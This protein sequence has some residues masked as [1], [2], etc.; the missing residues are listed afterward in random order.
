MELKEL[1]SSYTQ[2]PTPREAVPVLKSAVEVNR[3]ESKIHFTASCFRMI[4]LSSRHFFQHFSTSFNNSPRFIVFSCGQNHPCFTRRLQLPD[5]DL[6]VMQ[7]EVRV[8]VLLPVKMNFLLIFS[9][10]I[11]DLNLSCLILF[12][13]RIC[14]FGRFLL[15]C[16]FC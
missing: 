2:R 10:F 11:I 16:D 12:L 14:F 5:G 4:W 9:S 3:T 7:E 6:D 15:Y 8:F 1:L 13:L